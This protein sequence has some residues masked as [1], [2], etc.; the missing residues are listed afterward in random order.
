MAIIEDHQ[1]LYGGIDPGGNIWF[2]EGFSTEKIKEG[3]FVIRFDQPF[4]EL[5]APVCTINGHEWKTFD[6]S[7]AI[8]EIEL[9]Y[10]IC[11]TSTMDRPDDCAFTFIVFGSV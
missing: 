8:V 9:D 7:V 6:K 2:G 10:F 11:V 3:T 1:H 5:P 4:S